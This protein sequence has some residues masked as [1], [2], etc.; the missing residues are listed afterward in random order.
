MTRQEIIKYYFSLGFSLIPIVANGKKPL[1]NWTRY[2]SERM[3]PEELLAFGNCNIALIAGKLSGV[4]ILDLDEYKAAFPQSKIELN[5]PLVATTPR[6]GR[7]G[8]F[9][10]KVGNRS[11]ANE[12]LA[13]DM[14][15]EGG[16]VLISPSVIDGKAYRFNERPTKDIL[17]ALPEIPQEVLKAIVPES[18]QMAGERFDISSAIGSSEGG[19]NGIMK[20]AILSTL[21]KHNEAEWDTKAWEEIIALNNTFQPPLRENELQYL[22][23][24][25]K[26][27]CRRNPK[28]AKGE[29]FNKAN[30]APLR[31]RPIL[32]SQ[33]SQEEIDTHEEREKLTTGLKPLDNIFA[34]STGFYVIC[35]NPGSG[36]GFFATWLTRQFYFNYGKKS[37][38]FSLEMGEP[39]VRTRLKQQW[40]DLTESQ[41]YNGANIEPALELM[42][43]DVII[44]YPF[45]QEDTAYQTPA[46]FEKDL[47]EFYAKG[48]R[49]FHFDHLHELEGSNVNDTNQKITEE[50]GKV[51]QRICK[52]HPD[53]WLFVFAQPNGAAATKSII[54]RTDILGSKSITQKC[55]MFI[56]L[57][58]VLKTNSDTGDLVIDADNREVIFWVD[59]N[60]ITSN[61]YI[62]A[63]IYLSRT[64]NFTAYLDSDVQKDNDLVFD[65]P[66]TKIKT[67][68]KKSAV[69][70][71]EIE[72]NERF[73]ES[74]IEAL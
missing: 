44:V 49:V 19:R 31:T 4:D 70:P 62:G 21:N 22:F 20:S 14:K 57:N 54:K 50:W 27:F 33:F 74:E 47:E 66:L 43:E 8:Y 69:L 2:Q 55:E 53:I 9:K 23:N 58:R 46:N 18:S 59:K 71:F 3:T 30:E 13:I 41:F 61:L 65:N 32:Y 63:K 1:T 67:D 73:E 10:H 28:I 60:R 48:Y 72:K 42:R 64:G 39:L 6:G 40:S 25:E 38:L 17:D 26:G 16:Y 56:S 7:H 15:S 45:G 11:F 24:Y 36:K 51:F 52:K 29:S 34:F 5:T 12:E 68:S 35:A 37:V